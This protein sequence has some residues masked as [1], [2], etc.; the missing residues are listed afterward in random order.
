MIMEISY[1]QWLVISY[2]SLFVFSTVLGGL[3][4]AALAVRK[5]E[6][7]IKNMLDKRRSF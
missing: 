1:E 7:I 6:R 3:V 2:I 4:G 5:Y